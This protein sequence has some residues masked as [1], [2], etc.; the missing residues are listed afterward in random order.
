MT[1]TC[2]TTTTT[3]ILQEK[4][5]HQPDGQCAIRFC[6]TRFQQGLILLDYCIMAWSRFSFTWCSCSMRQ[7][8]CIRAKYFPNMPLVTCQG[9]DKDNKAVC[10]FK[11]TT[12]IE[13][14]EIQH[15]F[16]FKQLEKVWLAE[17][18]SF[19]WGITTSATMQNS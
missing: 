2:T 10:L 11:T 6:M 19:Q 14:N 16:L 15:T 7:P 9:Q 17:N 12:T 5:F 1:T 4:G 18:L 3:T 8:Q 13:K